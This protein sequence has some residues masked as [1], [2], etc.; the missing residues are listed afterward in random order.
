MSERERWQ[1]R[2]LKDGQD[3]ESVAL[4]LGLNLRVVIITTIR[5][6]LNKNSCLASHS[7]KFSEAEGV[8]FFNFYSFFYFL[9]LFFFGGGGGFSAIS[10]IISDIFVVVL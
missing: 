5:P 4:A 3:I 2:V 7:H 1:S 10:V 8:F 9:I 6:N